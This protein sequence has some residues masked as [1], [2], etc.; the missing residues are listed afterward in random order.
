M[1]RKTIRVT[2]PSGSPDNLIKLGTA[3]GVKNEDPKTLKKLQNIDPAAL[4]S[5]V[6]AAKAKRSEAADLEAQAQVLNEAANVILGTAPGQT[7]Q[8]PGTVL[9]YITGA[10]DELLSANRGNEN[11]LEPWGFSVVIGTASSPKRKNNPP[12]NS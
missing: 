10:R 5:Q 9:Y 12:T 3:I 2:I 8:T 1:A 4:A 7:N 11:A 6:A